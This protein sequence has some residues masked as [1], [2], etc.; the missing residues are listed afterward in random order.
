MNSG[1]NGSQKKSFSRAELD[2]MVSKA[3]EIALKTPEKAAYILTAWLQKPRKLES[4]RVHSPVTKK[5]A[6]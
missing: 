6:G 4:I 3:R 5:K 1:Q 2:L